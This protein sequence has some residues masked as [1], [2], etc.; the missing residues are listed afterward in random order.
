M[1][2]T[3]RALM[4]GIRDG[5]PFIVVV[6]PFAM[7]FGVVASETGLSAAQTIVFSFAVIAGAA[8]FAAVQLI[9][10]N[11]PVLIVVATALAV[12]L[13]MAMYSASIAPYL[14]GVPL[15][16]R[17][18]MSYLLVDQSYAIGLAKFETTPDMTPPERV[19]Y[20]VGTMALNMPL[21]YCGTVVG[22]LLGSRIP[23]EYAL[24]FAVPIT[25]LALVGPMLKT[26]PHVLAALTSVVLAL[27][28]A[29]IPY[30]LGLMLA[31][32]AAM[33]VGAQVELMLERRRS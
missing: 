21:W 22:A 7:L 18:A 3:K 4:L 24:D 8:Q 32:V 15:W 12:N 31:A 26:A 16:K 17:A 10:E 5:L 20:F 11:A 13:R 19:A 30:N 14:R 25:F 2:T 33:M 27:L 29:F 1:T 9:A 28:L 6:A 23:P